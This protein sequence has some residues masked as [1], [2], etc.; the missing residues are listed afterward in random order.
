M[1]ACSRRAMNSFSARVTAAFFDVSPLTATA[2]SIKAG[3]SARLVAT[4]ELHT[5]GYTCILR[6]GVRVRNAGFRALRGVV[7]AHT[8]PFPSMP[9]AALD[10]FQLGDELVGRFLAV[11]VEQTGVVGVEQGV[12]D[13]GKAGALATLDDDSLA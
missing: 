6:P 8:S 1:R 5:L 2:R 7:P 4:A 11:G 13:A 9:A 12:L 10:G 3:S